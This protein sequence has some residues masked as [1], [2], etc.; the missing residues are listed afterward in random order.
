MWRT[1]ASGLAL[2]RSSLDL[3]H[4]VV[5]MITT[6]NRQKDINS[7]SLAV[8]PFTK[9]VRTE[10]TLKLSKA[11]ISTL[12]GLRTYQ[13]HLKYFLALSLKINHQLGWK[14]CSS[15]RCH[16]IPHGVEVTTRDTR[17][18]DLHQGIIILLTQRRIYLFWRCR[19]T[20]IWPS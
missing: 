11:N 3:N 1:E 19:Q 16:K 18:F 10:E 17:T 9:S 4:S 6:S 12:T 7:N 15:S 14:K 5:S 2:K 13:C 20:S 8:I